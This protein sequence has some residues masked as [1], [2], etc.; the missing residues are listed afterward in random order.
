MPLWTLS[1]ISVKQKLLNFTSEQILNWIFNANRFLLLDGEKLMKI[2]YIHLGALWGK[3]AL[4]LSGKMS[5]VQESFSMHFGQLWTVRIDEGWF[6][7]ECGFNVIP[8]AKHLSTW[9]SMNSNLWCRN[10]TYAPKKDVFWKKPHYSFV[11][12]W[13]RNNSQCNI[14]ILFIVY[15]FRSN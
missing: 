2:N 6:S 10:V 3:S 14:S 1:I 8:R 12:N 4:L 5:G 15:I 9:S 13:Q 11:N 7:R